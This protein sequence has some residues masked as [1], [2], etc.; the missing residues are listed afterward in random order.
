MPGRWRAPIRADRKDTA[1]SKGGRTVGARIQVPAWDAAENW[2]VSGN[3][4][5]GV[6]AVVPVGG[7]QGRRGARCRVRWNRLRRPLKAMAP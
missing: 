7:P 3:G 4:A 2:A 5:F 1:A 6:A